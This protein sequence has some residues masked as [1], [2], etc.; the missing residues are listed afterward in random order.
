MTNCDELLK[1]LKPG[2][3]INTYGNPSWY[4]FWLHIAYY[5]IKSY[6]KKIFE[7]CKFR[8]LANYHHVHTML[9]FG[10]DHTF[11][12]ELPCATYKYIENYANDN[13]TIYRLD[14]PL[15]EEHIDLMFRITQT[16]Y[17]VNYDIGQLLDI[18]IN[19]ILGYDGIRLKVFDAGKKNKVCSVGVRTV[20]EK[21]NQKFKLSNKKG[22]FLFH[23]L[24]FNK[25]EPECYSTF[26]GVDVEATT[27]AHF[28]NTNFFNGEFKFVSSF[29][30]GKR[31]I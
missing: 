3:V 19:K 31:I 23:D 29:N 15:T 5:G 6:Q 28:A 26:K 22:K 8:S 21:L 7:K 12:V 18:A 27:P 24:A 20:F 9:Y 13:F 16:M 30:K 17:G 25:W 11:S 14:R 4:E 10:P 1:V 2:D